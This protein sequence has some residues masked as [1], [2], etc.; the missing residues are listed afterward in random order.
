MRRR[1]QGW[2]LVTRSGGV[3]QDQQI[4]FR[5]LGIDLS[6]RWAMVSTG[7]MP[8]WNTGEGDGTAGGSTEYPPSGGGDWRA[9][10]RLSAAGLETETLVVPWYYP[11]ELFH[12][13][14]ASWDGTMGLLAGGLYQGQ[15]VSWGNNSSIDP[16]V[17]VSIRAL[18]R[19]ELEDELIVG[20]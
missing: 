5:P 7:Y 4:D 17:T 15:Q 10:Y 6:R 13:L 2:A 1:I 20:C 3:C 11:L 9:F 8:A 14:P 12:V 18:R 16:A 19:S